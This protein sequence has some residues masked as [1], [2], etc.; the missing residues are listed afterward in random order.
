MTNTTIG[1]QI[2]RLAAVNELLLK[3][4]KEECLDYKYDRMIQEM[5]NT[6]WDSSVANGGE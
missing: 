4:S 5:Q 2:D 3:E 6:S 1:P